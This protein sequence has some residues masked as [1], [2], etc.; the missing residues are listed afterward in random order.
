MWDVLKRTS[1]ICAIGKSRISASASRREKSEHADDA[2]K[3][4]EKKMRD[5]GKKRK[6]TSSRALRAKSALAR[7]DVTRVLSFS[8]G[9][10]D[11]NIL[12]TPFV[13]PRRKDGSRFT[14]LLQRIF[15]ANKRLF[16]AIWNISVKTSPFFSCL[17]HFSAQKGNKKQNTAGRGTL[18]FSLY[19]AQIKIFLM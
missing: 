10:F 9:G 7:C 6:L 8:F 3:R 15:I 19:C 12:K 11:T 13:A 5:G 16:I 2:A 4:E 1:A 18:N 14:T 17:F